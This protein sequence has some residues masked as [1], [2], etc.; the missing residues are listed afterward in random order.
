MEKVN[1]GQ[2]FE[3]LNEQR[4]K[5]NHC[6]GL[7]GKTYQQILSNK[8]SWS[9]VQAL[10]VARNL[11]TAQQLLRADEYEKLCALPKFVWLSNIFERIISNWKFNSGFSLDSKGYYLLELDA[12][13]YFLREEDADI[14]FILLP[15]GDDYQ[16][17]EFV[18]SGVFLKSKC[19][20]YID[21]K[22]F[23][24]SL[25]TEFIAGFF[26]NKCFVVRVVP[27][28]KQDK[29]VKQQ[30]SCR[31][32]YGLYLSVF[33]P[34]HLL[35]AQKEMYE[36]RKKLMLFLEWK[37]DALLPFNLGEMSLVEM[38]E[39]YPFVSK[40]M[41]MLFLNK[42]LAHKK[43]FS[44]QMWRRLSY[45]SEYSGVFDGVKMMLQKYRGTQEVDKKKVY[46]YF[47]DETRLAAV[48]IFWRK[49]WMAEMFV[50][51]NLNLEFPVLTDNFVYFVKTVKNLQEEPLL[52]QLYSNGEVY[53]IWNLE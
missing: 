44:K 25:E 34:K 5:L 20:P 38:V 51:S 11:K 31:C 21:E 52:K 22:T 8:E 42:L 2:V 23:L 13:D 36:L 9:L 37:T 26:K 46:F 10:N 14:D 30:R 47:L 17:F 48:R 24:Y 33:R 32:H 15:Y 4:K 18:I 35:F 49:G 7:K 3:T 40:K 12:I 6:L 53:Y 27:D 29:E 45:L 41:W 39:T 50:E 1:I 19:Y 16:V 28:I 43:V